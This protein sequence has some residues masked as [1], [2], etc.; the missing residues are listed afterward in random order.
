MEESKA[1][2]VKSSHQAPK[3]GTKQDKSSSKHPELSMCN[4]DSWGKEL[5]HVWN[6]FSGAVLPID[7]EFIENV[8]AVRGMILLKEQERFFNSVLK[9]RFIRVSHRQVALVANH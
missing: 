2:R 5:F 9:H 8:Q 1:D 6:L 7:S 3:P 4:G